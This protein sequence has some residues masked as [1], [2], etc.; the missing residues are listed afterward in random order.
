MAAGLTGINQMLPKELVN[1]VHD[2]VLDP[3]WALRHPHREIVEFLCIDSYPLA[4]SEE[5]DKQGGYSDSLV[6]VLKR[7]ILDHEVKE[8]TGFDNKRS[9][10]GFARKLLKRRYHTAFE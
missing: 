10:Q 3:G 2:F 1:G 7:M 4:V 5:E 6:T 8:N 9:V